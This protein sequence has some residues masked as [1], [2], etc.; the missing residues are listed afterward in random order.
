MFNSTVNII[1]FNT[2]YEILYEI[3]DVL[4]FEVKNYAN[5]EKFIL[6]NKESKLNQLN[7]ILISK[8]S[9][10]NLFESKKID[11]RK[12]IYLDELP[13]KMEPLIQK[14]NIQLIKQKYNFQSNI[15]IKNYSL[16]LNTRIINKTTIQLKLTEK[17]IDILLFL[18]E[19]KSPQ[20]ISILQQEVWSYSL[21]LETHTVETHIYRLRKKMKE[22]FQ[23]DNFILSNNDGYFIK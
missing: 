5:P 4:K 3:K 6:E 22:K 7:F 19:S 9:N 2:L 18:H 20:K 21:D 11:E 16:N 1:A 12:M 13:I 8:S 15:N 10:K 23:D 17:E 14:I